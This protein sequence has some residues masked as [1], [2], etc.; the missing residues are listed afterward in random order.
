MAY[1]SYMGKILFVDLS[2]GETEVMTPDENF[3]REYIGGYGLGVRV[4]FERIKPGTDPLGPDNIIGFVTGPFVGTKSHAAGRFNVVFKSPLTGGWGDS[5]CGGHFG[6]KLKR[7]G[8]D[9][10]FFTGKAAKPVAVVLCDGDIEIRD[11]A[12]LWGK[13]TTEAEDIFLEEL[14]KGYGVCCIGPAGEKLSKIAAVMHDHGRCAARMGPGGVMGSKNLKAFAVKGSRTV[15]ISDEQAYNEVLE[16]LKIGATT[17]K[18]RMF[19]R[20]STNG[21]CG[22]Y[23]NNVAIQDAPTQNW[24]ALSKDLYPLEAAEKVGAAAYLPLKKRVYA[25]AQCPI[26]CGAILEAKD[27]D[28]NTYE[29]HRPEYETI[30]CFGSLLVNDDIDVVM[31]ANEKCNRYGIDTISAGG[32]IGFAME[33][34]EKGILTLEDTDGLDL[35][36]GNGKSILKMLDLMVERSGIG[37][38]FADGSKSAA[39]KLGKRAEDLAIHTGGVELAAHDPRCWP[40]FGYGYVFDATPGHHCQGTV[41]FMEHGWLDRDI[42]AILDISKLGENKYDYSGKGKPLA[43]LNSWFHFF[44]GTGLCILGKFAYFRYP[45]LEMLRAVAGWS[46]FSMEDALEAGERINTLRNMFNIREGLIAHKDFAL[47]KRT[48]GIP[49]FE[50]GPTAGITL[51]M[52]RVRKDYYAEMDWDVE[53]GVPSDEKLKKLKLYDIVKRGA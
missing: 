5:S 25:C 29:T 15:E 12:H 23:V 1:G 18:S 3:Y 37:A 39:E 32:T 30:S 28:G 4:L 51:D 52:D 9:A 47:P 19:E 34:F 14:G 42:N 26:H 17:E 11:A 16:I 6:P 2:S 10:V 27:E 41:G 44:N 49:P 40:G 36:W 22:V 24:K 31:I 7:T 21:T 20:I 50:D 35:S 33:C 53:T 46:G 13:D 48:Q 8:Y 43:M 38:V 45:V